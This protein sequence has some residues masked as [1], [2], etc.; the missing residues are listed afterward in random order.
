M[1]GCVGALLMMWAATAALLGLGACGTPEP[2]PAD[3][4]PGAFKSAIDSAPMLPPS[5]D[6]VGVAVAPEGQRYVLDCNSGLYEIDA[7][8]ARQVFSTSDARVRVRPVRRS[9]S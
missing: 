5:A 8:G 9:G 7:A 4:P 1:A 3:T 2:P 6:V